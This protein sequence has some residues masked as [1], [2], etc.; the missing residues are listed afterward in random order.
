MSSSSSVHK[1]M[2]DIEQAF[3]RLEREEA[4]SSTNKALIKRFASTWLAKGFTKSRVVKLVFCLRKL[5][6]ILDKPFETASRD[7]LIALIGKLEQLPYAEHS[8]YDF[9]VVLKT[10]YKW[11]KGGNDEITPPEV[12][13]LKPRLKSRHKLPE[14]LITPEDVLKLA[15]AA[16]NLRDKALILVLYETGCRIGE[17]LTLKLKNV[18]FDQH[19]AILRVTGKTGDRRVRVISSSPALTAWIEHYGSNDSEAYLWPPR[20]P[21]FHKD[22]KPAEY[23]SIYKMLQTLAEKSGLQKKIFPHLFRHSRATALA[24]KLTEAQMKEY[25][26]WTQASDMAS[27]YVHMSGRDVDNA[28][29][30]L[31]GEAQ[32]EV[33]AEELQIAFCRRC[34]EKNS[35]SSMFCS[36]CGTPFD[37]SI[38]VQ[39]QTPVTNPL[40]R[41]LMEDPEVKELMARKAI[42]RGLIDR[43]VS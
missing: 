4:I 12:A 18:S 33:K 24:S 13:W 39:D 41:E 32:V 35:P 16:T 43:M 25:F 10:F 29:L 22:N 2:N 19:G 11:L 1:S 8:K 5:A 27:V 23:R 15:Q 26:G 34:R 3:G 30:A 37:S 6:T 36:R 17:I 9:K 14:E 21:N 31:H 7:D 28:L 20:S 38:M 40:M 42:E